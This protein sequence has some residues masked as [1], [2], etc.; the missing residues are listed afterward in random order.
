[1]AIERSTRPAARFL[2]GAVRVTAMQGEEYDPRE[3]ITFVELVDAAHVEEALLSSFVA[4]EE[5]LLRQFRPD[6][7]LTLVCNPARNI[8]GDL[9]TPA[10]IVR[11]GRLTRVEPEFPKPKWQ[12]MHTKLMLLFYAHHMRFVVTSANLE[13]GDWAVMQNCV[14]VQDFPMDRHAVFAAN[15]FG[16]SLAYALHDMHVPF[17]IVA[18]LNNVD[19]SAARARIVTSVPT[20]GRR[21]NMNMERYGMERLA[22]VVAD[23]AAG[24]SDGGFEP[25]ARLFCVGSSLGAMD[26]PW[27][28]D[29]YLCAHGIEPSGLSLSARAHLV[30]DDIIDIGVGFHTQDDVARCMFG[31]ECGSRLMLPSHMYGAADFPQ[32]SLC[33]VVPRVD[34]SL[35]H[36]KLIAA[37]FGVDQRNGWVYIGSHNFTP[38]AWGRLR[39]GHAT[40]Y[41]NY[42]LGV[43]LPH[44]EYTR[45]TTDEAS[46]AW[47]GLRLPL[48]V[49]LVWQPYAR[50]DVPF[51][52]S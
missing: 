37:R 35:V 52:S 46:V 14:F 47:N 51:C 36:A 17:S 31:A 33:R 29:F 25:S 10:P 6:T 48:P 43:V 5:W 3:A 24:S 49:K 20:G 13:P 44:A 23:S 42:E 1:M 32:S 8:G 12:I 19:F 9:L 41:N 50:D 18:Q 30:P 11:A 45:M 7:R 40:Y 22:S 16:L 2:E 26:I 21:H 39:V 27:M 28:R 38:A 15:E 4:D 34:G